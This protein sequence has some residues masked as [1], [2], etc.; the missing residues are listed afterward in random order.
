MYFAA[1]GFNSLQ[2]AKDML[3]LFK[4]A[5]YAH[6]ALQCAF[7]TQIVG[8]AVGCLMS[9]LMM[10]KITTKKMEI[11]KAVEGSNVWFGQAL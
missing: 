1:Y 10:E 11:L 3:K 4:V 2:Q 5:Q 9:Y 6:L 8:T 7:V